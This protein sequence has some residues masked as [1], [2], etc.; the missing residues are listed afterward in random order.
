MNSPVQ[1]AAIAAFAYLVAIRWA[2]RMLRY[3]RHDRAL[4]IFTLCLAAGATGFL[5]RVPAL[6]T[7][8]DRASGVANLSELFIFVAFLACACLVMRWTVLWAE[9]DIPEPADSTPG[10][11]TAEPPHEPAQRVPR[12]MFGGF[13]AVVAALTALFLA[14]GHRAERPVDFETYYIRDPHNAAFIL[15]FLIAFTAAWPVA[16]LRCRAARRTLE[17]FDERWAAY[18]M[19][20]VAGGMW[21]AALY[22]A[23]Q[24]AIPLEALAGADS[25]VATAT[26]AVGNVFAT[27]SPVHSIAGVT[28][29][30]WGPRL[31]RQRLASR[32]RR[33]QAALDT[34]WRTLEPHTVLAPVYRR[35][36]PT[37]GVATAG[38]ST[39]PD[40]VWR[41]DDGYRG[42]SPYLDADVAACARRRAMA[43]GYRG[44]RLA[45]VTE[46][47]VLKAALRSARAGTPAARRHSIPHFPDDGLQAARWQVQVAQALALLDADGQPTICPGRRAAHLLRCAAAGVALAAMGPAAGSVEL[48]MSRGELVRP[49]AP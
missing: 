16:A 19:R 42:I 25:A 18:G 24:A 29:G 1:Y 33:E 20:L 45:A 40:T 12:W 47:A 2:Y 9:P 11:P 41:I 49:G 36:E 26:L 39:V 38:V 31:E 44:E 43:R 17:Q 32:A 46:A 35:L 13:A 21:L 6:Y 37:L 5:L 14:A 34:L 48:T 4:W 27:F 7:A 22:A 30:T 10:Q 23:A 8:V 15:L 3:R 28:C